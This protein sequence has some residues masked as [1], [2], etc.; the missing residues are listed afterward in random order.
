VGAA[1]RIEVV[2]PDGTLLRVEGDVS[3]A[4]LRRVVAVL[5]A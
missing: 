3:M 5:R 4:T 1:G 2:L